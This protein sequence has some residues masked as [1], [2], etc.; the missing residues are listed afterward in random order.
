[1]GANEIIGDLQHPA[2]AGATPV[3]FGAAGSWC[4]GWFH[5][6]RAPR[7]GTGVV[8]CRPL[9]YEASC[10][11]STYLHL[12]QKLA[13][14]GFDV[15]RFDYHGTADSAGTDADA[16]RVAAWQDSTMA[17]I[18]Q[19]KQ[20]AGVSRVS[21]FG[22]RIGAA[23]AAQA[24]DRLGGVDNLVLWAPCVTGRALVRE[25]RA[26][27]GGRIAPGS[28]PASLE[29]YGHLYTGETLAD[30]GT[31]DCKQ[32][33]VRPAERVL[34]IGRDDLPGGEAALAAKYRELGA[35]VQVETWPGY[36][37]MMD[38]PHKGRVELSTLDLIT[39]WMRAS[40]GAPD[41]ARTHEET[42]PS[43]AVDMACSTVR[44]TVQ[45]FGQNDALFGIL[46]EPVDPAA[47]PA[48]AQTG[49]LLL[50]VGGHYRIG[51]GRIYVNLAR[52]L[53]G[54]GYRA[55]RF[56][57][58]GFGDSRADPNAGN[59]TLYERNCDAD[60]DAA[61]DLMISRGCTKIVLLGI[62]TG[63]FLAFQTALIDPRVDS[64]ILLNTLRLERKPA[65]ELA[66]DRAIQVS[67][68]H[69]STH[70][71]RRALLSSS[72]YR[73]LLRG[74]V[75]LPGIASQFRRVIGTRMLQRAKRLLR[76]APH[77]QDLRTQI[78]QLATRGTDTLVVVA[79]GDPARDYMELHLGRNGSDMRDVPQFRFAVIEGADHTL[80]DGASQRSV[81]R[82]VLEHL[83]QRSGTA[84]TVSTGAVSAAA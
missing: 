38:E 69:K 31:L 14:A 7:R 13:S 74:E 24:A 20:R 68:V 55:L 30:L 67:A 35:E 18:D 56:D 82:L 6:A 45:A 27:S 40:A 83:N 1:M 80:S 79:A 46:A 39:D 84:R 78:R 81:T 71:Y 2:M 54:A 11:Y 42:L 28:D 10:S 19:L 9:G 76:I 70:F 75:D 72:T 3:V 5:P 43:L 52:A 34:I 4:F 36:A 26:A 62:C 16:G 17:A 15:F 29:A 64:Q 65:T 47:C 32:V 59:G 23:L 51:P 22:V 33:A 73:K 63:S 48:A 25:L 49:V 21:L 60:I 41:V 50:N 77:A 12:A 44:E 61:I 58:A 57:V 8:L 53:A 66:D 37:D